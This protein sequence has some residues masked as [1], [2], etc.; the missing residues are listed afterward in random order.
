M[1]SPKTK[2]FYVGYTSKFPPSNRV[3][4]HNRGTCKSTRNGRKWQFVA[5][6]GIFDTKKEALKFEK[7]WKKQKKSVK[8][9]PSNLARRHSKHAWVEARDGGGRNLVL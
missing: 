1:F 6:V 2:R 8:Q 5:A 4:S 7:L 9:N 3:R